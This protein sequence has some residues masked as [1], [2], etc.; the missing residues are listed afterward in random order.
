MKSTLILALALFAST[1]ARAERVDVG[2]YFTLELP[3]SWRVISSDH[4]NGDGSYPVYIAAGRAAGMQ[5]IVRNHDPIAIT[6]DQF[7]GLTEADLP[8]LAEW[9][10]RVGQPAPRVWKDVTERG[11][12]VLFFRYKEDQTRELTM[13]FWLQD[14]TFM[15]RFVYTMDPA[16]VKTINQII[17][18]VQTTRSNISWTFL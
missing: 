18:S 13:H 12:P 11:L 8:A 1:F 9:N 16:T 5:V 10:Q 17:N 15:L 3:R 7:W 4:L 14:R 6:S 2:G